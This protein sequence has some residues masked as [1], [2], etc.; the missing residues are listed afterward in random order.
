MSQPE[1][2]NYT[3]AAVFNDARGCPDFIDPFTGTKWIKG[4][5]VIWIS[6]Y[7]I[8]T[9]ATFIR[10]SCK[11]KSCSPYF[12][13]AYFYTSYISFP[14]YTPPLRDNKNGNTISPVAKAVALDVGHR[15]PRQLFRRDILRIARKQI[16]KANSLEKL[17]CALSLYPLTKSSEY[18][19]NREK[20]RIEKTRH[21]LPD[22]PAISTSQVSSSSL[23]WSFSFIEEATTMRL[24]FFSLRT[25]S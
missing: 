7:L 22:F 13:T 8:G 19:L 23:C 4:T 17:D 1:F 11:E 3:L 5:D 12:C 10:G 18:Q 2:V 24:P 21:S 14:S 9:R 16:Y 20:P 25:S 6:W 15:E